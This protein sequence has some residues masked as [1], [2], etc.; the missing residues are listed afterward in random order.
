MAG[1]LATLPAGAQGA[2]PTQT[3]KFIVAVGAGG[4]ADTSARRVGE[5][6]SKA[7]G[8]PIIVENM[9]GASGAIAS[10]TV[11]RAAPDGHTLLVGTNTSHAGNVSL[12]KSLPYD[13]VNDFAPISRIGLAGLTLGVN[14]A[15]PVTS[16]KELMAYA[17]ASPGKLSYGSGAGSARFAAEMFKEKAGVDIIHVP[18]RS[19]NQALTDLISGQIQLLFG[20]TTLMLPQVRAGS[21]K[22][23][24]VSS[25]ARS[26]LA[27]EMPTIAE[28]GVPGYELV[29]WIALFAPAKTPTAIVERL[30]AEL[31]AILSDPEFASGLAALGIEAAPTSPEGL[32]AWVVSET[33]KWSD[34]AKTA[35]IK[36][37]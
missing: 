20:D 34:I 21:I 3:I 14:N 25:A 7:L 11:A 19:N 12:L 26:K 31:K 6:L 30:N 1:A 37:E 23:L 18:Y 24:G 5:R 17:K 28:A 10:Q 33:A 9:P 8:Q 32:R 36:P 4:A 27:P 16:V 22:G 15:V 29:G 13:P 35:G 2:Y